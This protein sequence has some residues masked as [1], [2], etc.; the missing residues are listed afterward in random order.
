MAAAIGVSTLYGFTATSGSHVQET[1]EEKSIEIKTARNAAGVEV[2]AKPAKLVT[3][4]YTIRLKGGTAL[5]QATAGSIGVS[6][7]RVISVTNRE[8][9]DDLG[10]SEVTLKKYSD[11]A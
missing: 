8:T 3:H 5:S 1:T 4:N 6:T 10:E 2:V 9:A 7:A 11:R